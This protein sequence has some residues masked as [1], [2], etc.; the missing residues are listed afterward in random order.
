M[1]R[2]VD[3]MDIDRQN[4]L[5]VLKDTLHTHTH[6]YGQDSIHDRRHL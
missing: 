2:T 6:G 1:L 5:M 3:K 4:R